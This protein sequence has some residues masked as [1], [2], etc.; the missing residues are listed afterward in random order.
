MLCATVLYEYNSVT[1]CTIFLI[2]ASEDLFG[3]KVRIPAN[4][5][6][7]FY[8]VILTVVVYWEAYLSLFH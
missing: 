6:F 7:G 1:C 4:L 2:L 5:L 8:A 3:N